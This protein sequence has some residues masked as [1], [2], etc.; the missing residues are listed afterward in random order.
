[1]LD[2]G[3]L[4]GKNTAD[5]QIFA[6]SCTVD[7]KE[8]K[9]YMVPRGINMLYIMVAGGGGGGGNGFSGGAGTARGGGG[10]GSGGNGMH[11]WIPAIFLPEILYIQAGVGGQANTNGIA[12]YV[13]IAPDNSAT[14]NIICYGNAGLKGANGAGAGTAG[15]GSAAT[16]PVVTNCGA[17]G[18]AIYQ[19]VASSS[20]AGAGAIAGAAGTGASYSNGNLAGGGAG[21]G[22][23]TS[24]NFNGGAGAPS[25][26][27]WWPGVPAG[28]TAGD[29]NGGSWFETLEHHTLPMIFPGIGG[30]AAFN[31]AVG[32]DGGT[33]TFASGGGG[34]GAG[35]TGGNGG[36]GGDGLVIIQ[37]F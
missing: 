28:T 25:A 21:G 31:N 9:T 14:G 12:S 33:C 8:W 2:F 10:G 24:G 36:K 20:G 15:G 30:G 23:T 29:K 7:N 4:A 3:H 13:A 6:G 1:M 35:T 22:S 32:G 5:I 19:I 18:G 17:I 37:A 27:G 34:G 11:V 26:A 16:T